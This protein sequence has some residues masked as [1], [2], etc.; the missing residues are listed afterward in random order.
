MKGEQE[1]MT[2]AMD[3]AYWPTRRFR[4]ATF[5]CAMVVWLMSSGCAGWSSLGESRGSLL[6]QFWNRSSTPVETPGYDLYAESMAARAPSAKAASSP[7]GATRPDQT[8]KDKTKQGTTSPSTE[9]DEKPASSLSMARGRSTSRSADTSLRVTLGRP[10]TLPTLKDMGN[11][12]GPSLAMGA[13]TSWHRPGDGEPVADQVAYRAPEQKTRKAVRAG[14]RAEKRKNRT[15]PLIGNPHR[16]PRKTRFVRSW[17]R[18]IS[19]R[20]HVNLPGQDHTG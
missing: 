12:G 20:G 1:N 4:M 19:A 7:G 2:L 14:K 17:R 11:P 3:C 6:G 8:P 16:H 18:Q 10:E 15:P 5:V 9:N 13:K